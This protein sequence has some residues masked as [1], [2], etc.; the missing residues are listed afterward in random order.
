MLK[1]SSL[2]MTKVLGSLLVAIF[3]ISLTAVA[4]ST[5]PSVVKEKKMTVNSETN[6][7][8]VKEKKMSVKTETNKS[9]NMTNI[10]MKKMKMKN[11]DMNCET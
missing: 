6:N 11:N 9:M 4:V 5:E 3:V 10:G 7:I 1:Q 8:V 2:R